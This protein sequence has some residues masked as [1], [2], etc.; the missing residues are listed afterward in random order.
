MRLDVHVHLFPPDVVPR[1][2]EYTARD[3]FLELICSG[4]KQKYAAVE[5]LLEVMEKNDIDRAAICGFA[6]RD[7]GLCRVMNDYVLEAARQHPERLLAMTAVNPLDSE[8]EKEIRRCHEQGAAGV[9][10]LFPW[11]QMFSL[12]GPEAGKL[13]SICQERNLPL[14]LHINENVG[15]Y[16]PGKGDVSVREAAEYAGKYPELKIIYAHWGGGLFFYELMP[17]LKKQLQNVY[18]DTAASP[19]LYDKSI[20]RVVREIG[21]LHKVLLGTDYPLISPRRYLR[22]LQEAGLT[23]EESALIEGENAHRLFFGSSFR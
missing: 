5:D 20:Y 2:Q 13:A 23:P 10:E 12:E 22:E 4:P 6:S 18:Y 16:Y 7:E 19:F 11:G 15:H 14:L 1:I 3:P 17:E 9:G 8:M 21:I